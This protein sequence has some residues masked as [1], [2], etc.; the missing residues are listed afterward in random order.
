[1]DLFYTI[2]FFFILVVFIFIILHLRPLTENEVRILGRKRRKQQIREYFTFSENEYVVNNE[3]KKSMKPNGSFYE[4]NESLYEFPSTAAALLKYKKHEWIII[5][6]EK[7]NYI[8]TIWINKGF[9]KGKVTPYLSAETI[10]QKAK[11]DNISTVMFFHNHPNSNPSQYDCT[12]PS[13][14]DLIS[15]KYFA[16]T[17]NSK[18]IN[19]IEFVCERGMHYEYYLSPSNS[20]LP[21]KG[22]LVSINKINDESKWKNLGLHIERIF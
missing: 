22:F 20:F 4:I 13:K 1:M 5:G 9:D 16:S 18:N 6:F 14:Q 11:K 10:A 21:L 3:F 15:A 12:N 19:L 17:L 2:L 8:K 7:E